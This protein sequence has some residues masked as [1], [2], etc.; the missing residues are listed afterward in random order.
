MQMLMPPVQVPNSGQLRATDSARRRASTGSPIGLSTET[1]QN[2]TDLRE[3][4]SELLNQ[5]QLIQR[6][7]VALVSQANNAGDIEDEATD[8]S[9]LLQPDVETAF[10]CQD[11]IRLRSANPPQGKSVKGYKGCRRLPPLPN[12][13]ASD[14]FQG[15]GSD[16]VVT[17]DEIAAQNN[18]ILGVPKIR[19]SFGV[20]VV[21]TL[22]YT[23]YLL[24]AWWK[25][26]SDWE[27]IFPKC[28][29]SSNL[30]YLACES[31]CKLFWT[32]PIYYCMLV[33]VYF[34]QD[35][36]CIELYYAMLG[37]NVLV[38]YGRASFFSSYP[39]IFLFFWQLGGLGIYVFNW[40]RFFA[41]F[42]RTLPY[43]FPVLSASSMLCCTWDVEYR[44]ITVSKYAK[45]SFEDA[46]H[47]LGS[48]VFLRDYVVKAGLRSLQRGKGFRTK[49]GVGMSIRDLV[50]EIE[51]LEAE[52]KLKDAKPDIHDNHWWISEF[53][54]D[55]DHQDKRSTS[56]RFW[57]RIYRCYT[58]IMLLFLLGLSL[59]T[60]W[61]HDRNRDQHIEGWQRRWLRAEDSL[62][63]LVA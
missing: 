25:C 16:M 27:E 30:M 20:S 38:D 3:L 32:A 1:P 45:R 12:H 19:E 62:G 61:R 9:P 51:M 63:H 48:C 36:L 8:E 49:A 47:H 35:L 34:Y 18:K 15:H 37:H 46:L 31:S 26:T 60:Q 43:W 57:F 7:K 59:S 50:E 41:C 55:Q 5:L 24:T 4:E 11:T 39:V 53:I 44:L 23:I 22:G 56:F 52:G 33:V 6:A 40:D 13:K 42:M 54:Y 21:F 58:I 29:H 17:E 10:Q 14:H 2:L 28:E